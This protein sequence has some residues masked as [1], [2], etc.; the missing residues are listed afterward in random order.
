M[1]LMNLDQKVYEKEVMKSGQPTLLCFFKNTVSHS[2]TVI[3]MEEISRQFASLQLYVAQEEEHEFFSEKFHF[4][5]TPIF[6][7]L[8]NG[9]ER[10]RLMGSVSLERLSAFVT[11]NISELN[12]A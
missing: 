3:S 5:G 10:A 8:V 4:L 2:E 1:I 7:L 11:R 9:I 6:I 12:E